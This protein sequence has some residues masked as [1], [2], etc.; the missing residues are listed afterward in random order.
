MASAGVLGQKDGYGVVDLN[1]K[2]IPSPE[3]RSVPNVLPQTVT[4]PE[5]IPEPGVEASSSNLPEPSFFEDK[6]D[7]NTPPS[8]P[9]PASVAAASQPPP[10]EEIEEFKEGVP[11]AENFKRLRGKL[12]ETGEAIKA[13]EAENKTLKEKVAAYETASIVPEKI[14]EYEN[15]IQHL[16]KYEAIYDLENSEGYKEQVIKPLS[17][18]RE[19]LKALIKEY[20]LP[21]EVADQMLASSSKRELNQFLS[22]HFDNVGATQVSALVDEIKGIQGKARDLRE[23]P[24]K[25]LQRLELQHKEINERHIVERKQ[26]IAGTAKAAWQKAV[27]KI[28]KEGV[29]QA[30]ML[31]ADNPQQNAIALKHIQNGANEFSKHITQLAEDGIT[32]LSDNYAE[33]MA[34]YVLLGQASAFNAAAMNGVVQHHQQLEQNTKRTTN[35]ERPSI[36][37]PGRSVQ[38]NQGPAK[39]RDTG[40][41]AD[42][43]MEKVLGSSR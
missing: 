22:E 32:N 11:P 12:K 40:T 36:G 42:A 5:V 38:G 25:E 30:L 2:V 28:Q 10:P 39:P 18:K 34:S 15:K 31:N 3:I 23:H 14:Q 26:K 7:E 35:Y 33:A 19:S 43:L 13:K 1:V 8:D 16:S 37:A 29:V 6:K 20:A 9:A 27:Q 17:S 21:D 41:A 24:Q 4:N